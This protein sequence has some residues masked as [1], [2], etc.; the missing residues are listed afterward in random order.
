[1]SDYAK[2]LLKGIEGLGTVPIEAAMAY[3]IFAGSLLQQVNK[4]IANRDDL[5]VLIGRAPISMLYDNHK[6]HA[7]FMASVFRFNAFKMLAHVVPWVYRAYRNHGFS[8]DYFPVELKLWKEA[9]EQYL[10]GEYP[11]LTDVYQWMLENHQSFITLAGETAH[12]EV[13]VDEKWQKEYKNFLQGLIAGETVRCRDIFMAN[14]KD[15]QGFLE[16][17]L[18]VVQPAM[19][20]VGNWWEDGRI[21]VAEEHL[22]SSIVTRLIG[23]ATD[24]QPAECKHTGE[25]GDHGGFQRVP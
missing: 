17:C 7:M 5:S 11:A 6:N 4:K 14:T 22:A 10:E 20:Q 23:L 16:F 2:V 8:Y 1:M 13:Q 18:E 19:Y 12:E 24:G 21:S 9:I 25:G 15:R 3:E